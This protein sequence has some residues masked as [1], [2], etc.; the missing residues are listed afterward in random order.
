M[1]SP[2][3]A[4]ARATVL[5]VEATTLGLAAGVALALAIALILRPSAA[6]HLLR[7]VATLGAAVATLGAMGTLLAHNLGLGARRVAAE[8]E[9]DASPGPP[10]TVPGTYLA[11]VGG[12]L[13]A[14]GLFLASRAADGTALGASAARDRAVLCGLLAIGLQA[15]LSW[16]A[17]AAIGPS[18]TPLAELLQP[19]AVALL[20]GFGL[21]LV[22]GLVG[23]SMTAELTYELGAGTTMAALWATATTGR[24]MR[25]VRLTLRRDREQGVTAPPVERALRHAALATLAGVLV[26]ALV[27]A[28]NLATAHLNGVVLAGAALIVVG[29]PLRYA[30]ALCRLDAPEPPRCKSGLARL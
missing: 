24:V 21:A 26:P 25:G 15:T 2:P 28:A 9:A 18:A 10:A 12:A 13:L 8:V 11:A 22:I 5:A 23:E 1:L 3:L 16:R 19:S 6:I 27:I 7:P 29:H 30:L 17:S 4:R 14:V 20:A